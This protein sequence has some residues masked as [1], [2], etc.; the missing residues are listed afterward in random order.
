MSKSIL[1]RAAPALA[2]ALLAACTA[3]LPPRVAAPAPPSVPAPRLQT[4]TESYV[5]AESPAPG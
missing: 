5:T 1:L 2:I 4:V 3:T